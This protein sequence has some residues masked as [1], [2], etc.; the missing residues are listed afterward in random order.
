MPCSGLYDKRL[1]R[2]IV[3]GLMPRRY[4]DHNYCLTRCLFGQTIRRVD[5]RS[6]STS[7]STS[8]LSTGCVERR[9]RG[10][11]AATVRSSQL[12]LWR[13]PRPRDNCHDGSELSSTH[14]YRLVR[15]DRR[16]SFAL[17]TG[18]EVLAPRH[19]LS[20]PA[21]LSEGIGVSVKPPYL[22]VSFP[23]RK[24]LNGRII[25]ATLVMMRL[26]LVRLRN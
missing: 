23:E 2:D 22:R 10:K 4:N 9:Y 1:A 5:C 21:I 14:G 26:E 16:V 12:P 11:F 3:T 19:P 6:S 17:E 20:A 24:G 15:Q 25:C 18:Q 8:D 13:P 7:A